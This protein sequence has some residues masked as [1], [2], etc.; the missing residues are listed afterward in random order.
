MVPAARGAQFLL[1]D[2]GLAEPEPP[3][4]KEIAADPG[5][6]PALKD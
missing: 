5:G 2:G 6:D 1:I 4:L 3:P